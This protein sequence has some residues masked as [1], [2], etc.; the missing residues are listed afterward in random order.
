MT[1]GFIDD[2]IKYLVMLVTAKN[3]DDEVWRG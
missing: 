3:G 1:I 2:V